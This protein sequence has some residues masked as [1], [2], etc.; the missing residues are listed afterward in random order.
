MSTDRGRGTRDRCCARFQQIRIAAGYS[1][2]VRVRHNCR[3]SLTQRLRERVGNV[4]ANA[5]QEHT[6]TM[7]RISVDPLISAER[8]GL[9]SALKGSACSPL[10]KESA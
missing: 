6:G 10:N 8:C 1:S 3:G 4:M 5:K 2:A 7:R 9:H